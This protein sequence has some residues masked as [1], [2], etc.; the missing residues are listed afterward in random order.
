MTDGAKATAVHTT[1]ST[2]E[3][4]EPAL[5]R[6]RRAG[7]S[8][9][10]QFPAARHASPV[11]VAPTVGQRTPK[12]RRHTDDATARPQAGANQHAQAAFLR[13]SRSRPDSGNNPS[14]SKPAA[15]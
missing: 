11:A 13:A 12:P 7:R 1:A 4:L 6:P 9:E 3:A 10:N 14:R 15:V 8:T 5:Q 2:G